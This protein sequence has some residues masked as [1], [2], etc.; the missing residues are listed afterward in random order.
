MSGRVVDPGAVFRIPVDPT[1]DLVLLEP[2][3]APMLYTLV[4]ENRTHLRQWLPWVD[5][6]RAVGDSAAFIHATLGQFAR[7]EALSVG[8]FTQGSLAGMVGYHP[9]DWF[10]RRTSIGYWL[11]ASHQGRGLM[12]RAVDALTAH[13]F[14]ALGLHRL[15]IRAGVENRRSRQVAER[16]GYQLEGVARGNEW[17][18]ARFIDHAVYAALATEW[19]PVARSPAR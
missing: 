3:H 17:V 7:S 18:Q 10:N 6:T 16:V 13:A 15:E 14:A 9:I 4:D 1:L 5:A 8:I 12:T 11:A 19:R 2:R